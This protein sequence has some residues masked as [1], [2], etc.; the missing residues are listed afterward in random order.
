MANSYEPAAGAPRSLNRTPLPP[1]ASRNQPQPAP[2]GVQRGHGLLPKRNLR[3]GGDDDATSPQVLPPD[4][5]AIWAEQ[6]RPPA[7]GAGVEPG[8]DIERLGDEVIP[9]RSHPTEN[10]R[11]IDAQ[12]VCPGNPKGL[13]LA[14]LLKGVG[15][16]DQ[17]L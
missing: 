12:A 14:T 1:T 17:R 2:L 9:Q 8:G 4:A 15:G 6:S 5:D 13:Q 3:T 16:G 11:H 10:G 7:Y